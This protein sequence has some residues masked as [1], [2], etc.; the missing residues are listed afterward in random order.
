MRQVFF[1]HKRPAYHCFIHLESDISGLW[2]TMT[3]WNLTGGALND[4]PLSKHYTSLTPA[5]NTQRIVN[6]AIKRWLT[7]KQRVGV[8]QNKRFSYSKQYTVNAIRPIRTL[9]GTVF[10]NECC[11]PVS[12]RVDSC[13]FCICGVLHLFVSLAQLHYETRSNSLYLLEVSAKG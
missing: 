12:H 8:G 13:N 10:W 9:C 6:D 7:T 4:S 11:L 5:G 3:W 2:V 1:S